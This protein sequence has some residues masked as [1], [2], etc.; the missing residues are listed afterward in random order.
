[1]LVTPETTPRRKVGLATPRTPS[2]FDDASP[3]PEPMSPGVEASPSFQAGQIA[4]LRSNFRNL[5]DV[6]TRAEREIGVEGAEPILDHVLSTF[7]KA[8]CDKTGS[9]RVPTSIFEE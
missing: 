7:F 5:W 9:E 4:V 2:A 6:F 8:H 1:M 3:Y